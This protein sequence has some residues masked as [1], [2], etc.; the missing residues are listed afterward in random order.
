MESADAGTLWASATVAINAV[1]VRIAASYRDVPRQRH[2]V[3][4]SPEPSTPRSI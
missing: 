4:L 3:S 2:L 1:T